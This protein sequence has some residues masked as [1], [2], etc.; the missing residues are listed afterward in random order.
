MNTLP[1]DILYEVAAQALAHSDLAIRATVFVLRSVERRARRPCFLASV[2]Y[3]RV[4]GYDLKASKEALRGAAAC[5]SVD[6]LEWAF[7]HGWHD[8]ADVGLLEA[9]AGSGQINTLTWVHK[10]GF[11]NSLPRDAMRAAAR[12]GS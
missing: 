2:R 6:L 12:S 10:R 7:R 1:D 5:G 9:A 4:V 3:R 8:V 11:Y